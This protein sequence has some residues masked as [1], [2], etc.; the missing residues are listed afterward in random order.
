MSRDGSPR[1]RRTSDILPLFTKV[2]T[3]SHYELSFPALPWQLLNYIKMNSNDLID[4][5]FVFRDLGLLC[6][7]AQLPGTAYATAQIN[8]NYMGINQKYAHTRIYTDS[9]FTF[10]V[11]DDYRVI[12]FFE[13]WQEFISSGSDSNRS[14]KAFYHRMKFP[15][16]YKCDTMRLQ[17]FDKNHGASVEY[18]F[19]SAFPVNITPVSVSYDQTQILEISVSFAYDRYFFGNLRRQDTR[20]NQNSGMATNPYPKDFLDHAGNAVGMDKT[21]KIKN[22]EVDKKRD[23]NNDATSGFPDGP[24]IA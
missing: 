2:A 21:T 14:R 22:V 9:A 5:S 17:K 19:L 4:N 8:G 23:Q 24:Y 3:T 20:S 12:K 7:N 13:L 1:L 16:E 15:A 11:D 18:T 6:K 10:I